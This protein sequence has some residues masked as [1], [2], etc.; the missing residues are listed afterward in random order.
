MLPEFERG[1]EDEIYE[2]DALTN[3]LWE[4]VELL[5]SV[6]AKDLDAKMVGCSTPEAFHPLRRS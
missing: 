2:I 6:S 3:N 5:G 1:A 4:V